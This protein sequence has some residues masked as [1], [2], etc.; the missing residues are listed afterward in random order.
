MKSTSGPATRITTPFRLVDD[1]WNSNP[2]LLKGSGT[3][4]KSAYAVRFLTVPSASAR[5]VT[6]GFTRGY[7]GIHTSSRA[8]F[9]Y[10][11]WPYRARPQFNGTKTFQ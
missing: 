11:F 5:L 9:P 10:R 1:L 6:R 7:G 8:P 4:E 2:R 3:S